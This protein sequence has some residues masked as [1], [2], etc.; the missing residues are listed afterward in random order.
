M[1]FPTYDRE[2]EELARELKQWLFDRQDDLGIL[3][4]VMIMT[5]IDVVMEYEDDTNQD[6]AIDRLMAHLKELKKAL[7]KTQRQ[8]HNASG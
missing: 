2:S 8:K 4:Y 5:T 7:P 1:T 3:L 6:K